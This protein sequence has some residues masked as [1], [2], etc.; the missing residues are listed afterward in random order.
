MSR[1]QLTSKQHAFLEFLAEQVRRTKV[2]PTYRDIVER[3][4]YRS[5]NSVTQN[6][7][8]LEKKGYLLRDDHGYRLVG[9]GRGLPGTGFPVQGTVADGKLDVALSIEEITLNDLFPSLSTTFA[10]RMEQPVRGVDVSAGDYLLLENGVP[11]DA[12][13]VAVLLGGVAAVCRLVRDGSVVR[14]QFA[15]GEETTIANGDYQMLGRYAGHINRLG[16]YRLPERAATYAGPE[17]LEVI[18]AT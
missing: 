16:V 18:V 15:D 5:P 11:A 17:A 2:W 12:S 3:F 6:L 8:A 7:Q 13:M 1:K 10:L 4:G 9:Q 14:L